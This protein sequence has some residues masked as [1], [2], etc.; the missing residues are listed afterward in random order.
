[1][2]HLPILITSLV[3]GLVSAPTACL[4]SYLF[5]SSL[6]ISPFPFH[7]CCLGRG[8]DR[9]KDSFNYWLSHSR[10]T[11]EQSFGILMQ[12]WGMFWR[13]FTFSFDC[14]AMVTM[15]YMKLHN[16]CIDRNVEIPSCHFIGDVREGDDW[17]VYDNAREVNIF[18]RGRSTGDRRRDITDKLEQLGIVRPAQALCNSRMN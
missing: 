15:V 8:L 5:S 16:I 10:Q 12:H 3:P 2:K 7:I 14:W 6:S 4:T 11:I 13:P 17:V 1:M 18:L 9:D